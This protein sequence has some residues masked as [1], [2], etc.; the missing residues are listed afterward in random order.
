[1]NTTGTGASRYAC[2]STYRGS[3]KFS[4]VETVN[5]RNFLDGLDRQGKLKGFIDF[6]AYSQMWFIPW[7][8]TSRR[9]ND[10]E[11][12]VFNFQCYCRAFCFIRLIPVIVFSPFDRLCEPLSDCPT[13]D[14]SQCQ[15]IR[16]LTV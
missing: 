15:T 13:S 16:V 14:V 5:V 1:M 11:E 10:Y 12:Q 7:G 2:D 4:E 6:H 9:T 8:Y 3:T